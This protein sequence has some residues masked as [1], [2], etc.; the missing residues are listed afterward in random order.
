MHFHWLFSLKTAL[1]ITVLLTL[2]GYYDYHSAEA[3]H[4][5]RIKKEL[6]AIQERLL[7]DLPI[8]IWSKDEYG[9]L[10]EVKKYTNSRDWIIEANLETDIGDKKI[11]KF[12]DEYISRNKKTYK[13]KVLKVWEELYFNNEGLFVKVGTLTLKADT[14]LEPSTKASLILSTTIKIIVSN[15][16]ILLLAFSSSLL[17]KTRESTFR[18]VESNDD[19]KE[20]NDKLFTGKVSINFLWMISFLTLTVSSWITFQV[21]A[22]V[23]NEHLIKPTHEKYMS[24]IFRYRLGHIPSFVD[25]NIVIKK[26]G[27]RINESGLISYKNDAGEFLSFHG[28]NENIQYIL[29]KLPKG[30]WGNYEFFLLAYKDGT[31]LY[32]SRNTL[33]NLWN[34]L[35]QDGKSIILN[36]VKYR[37]KVITIEGSKYLAA[38][39]KYQD[40]IFVTYLPENRAYPERFSFREVSNSESYMETIQFIFTSLKDLI[41]SGKLMYI[42]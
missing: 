21:T 42:E 9:L 41:T 25:N 10:N 38:F 26:S 30:F 22:H 3:T 14:T 18:N 17:S 37:A 8:F 35:H 33:T 39:Y 34:I 31:V 5:D 27:D 23:V 12:V 29:D 19:K 32:D 28:K 13:P 24:R 36:D 40:W 11:S 2:F 7:F 20:E 1:V 4:S 15:L 16:L 6:I